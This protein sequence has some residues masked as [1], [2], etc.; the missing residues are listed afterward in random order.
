MW[1]HMIHGCMV[2]SDVSIICPT[3]DIPIVLEYIVGCKEIISHCST[4]LTNDII[5]PSFFHC[6]GHSLETDSDKSCYIYY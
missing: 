2:R 1:H 4:S 6:V 5:S 3:Y